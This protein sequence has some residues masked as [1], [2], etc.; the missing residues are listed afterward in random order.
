MLIVFLVCITRFK[1]SFAQIEIVI[2]GDSQ[3]FE[4]PSPHPSPSIVLKSNKVRSFVGHPAVVF[5]KERNLQTLGLIPF[6]KD[7]HA[8]KE[9]SN[10]S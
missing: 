9:T 1:I 10:L 5:L 2:Q 6:K 8:E 3:N 7:E 4:P